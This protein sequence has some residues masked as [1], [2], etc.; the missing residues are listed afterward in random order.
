MCGGCLFYALETAV[1]DVPGCKLLQ[2]STCLIVMS[3]D[4][5]A[6]EKH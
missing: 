1:V 2:R 6:E 5:V 4:F 3:A